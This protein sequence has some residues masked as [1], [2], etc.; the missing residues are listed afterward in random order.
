V[1]FPQVQ[2]FDNGPVPFDIDPFQIVQQTA[3]FPDQAEKRA[4]CAE[5]VFVFLQMFR[6]MGDTV[7]K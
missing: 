5:I 1:L 3:A 6:Q 4:L 2:G 7:G